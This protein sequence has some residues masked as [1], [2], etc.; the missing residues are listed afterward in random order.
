MELPYF[1]KELCELSNY[2]DWW[3]YVLKNLANMDHL[4]EALRNQIFE[5]LFLKAEIAKLSKEE[6]KRYNRSLKKMRDMNIIVAD[7]E[8][9]ITL[10]SKD[11]AALSKNIEALSRDNANKDRRIAELERKVRNNS[12]DINKL[13]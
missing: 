6:R 13:N 10:L 7:R 4:P 9:K 8:R 12:Q 11:I 1:T 3:M 2:I 5:S